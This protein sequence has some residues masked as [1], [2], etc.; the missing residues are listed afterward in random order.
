MVDIDRINFLARKQRSEGLTEEEK[1][2]QDKLRKEYIASVTGNLRAQ[3]DNTY[4]IDENGELYI[5]REVDDITFC[6]AESEEEASHIEKAK[7]DVK[8]ADYKVLYDFYNHI[9]NGLKDGSIWNEYSPLV[10]IGKYGDRM[11]TFARR[12]DKLTD[13]Q[14][15]ALV[16]QV[17]KCMLIDSI[18]LYKTSA[19]GDLYENVK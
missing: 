4:G 18:V 6:T 5:A 2:E 14:A 17:E 7:V 8:L 12:I 16:L 3:L 11:V 19:V 10:G 15:P 9:L 1:A 13:L